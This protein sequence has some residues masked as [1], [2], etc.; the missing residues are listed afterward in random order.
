MAGKTNLSATL[1]SQKKLLGKSSTGTHRADSNEPIPSGLQVATSAVFAED[2]PSSPSRTLFTVQSAGTGKPNTVEYVEFK[3]QEVTG[4]AYDANDFDSEAGSQGS[5]IHAYRLVL[6]E[7]YQAN[8]NSSVKGTYPFVDNQILHWTLGGLQMVSPGFSNDLPNPYDLKLYESD[9]SE[10]PLLDE[11]DWQIDYFSGIL[12]VQDYD[13]SKIPENAKGFIYVGKMLSQSLGDISDL[14][15]GG[16]SP[17]TPNVGWHAPGAGSISTTGSLFIGTSANPEISLGSVG[18]AIFNE[19]GRNSDFRIE[20]VNKPSAFKVDADT[21]QVLILSGGAGSSVNE[22]AGSDVSFYVSGSVDSRGTVNRGTSVFGG[23]VAVSGTLSVNLSDA[24]VGS[25]FVVTTDGKVGI[26]T[27]NP[28][29]KLSVGGNMEVGEYIYHKNDDHTFIRFQEDQVHIKAGNK[30]MIKMKEDASDQVLIL[31]GGVKAS[32]DPAQ[33]EDTNFFV[34]G[35]IG[36]RGTLTAGTSVFGGDLVTSGSAE[37]FGDLF[38]NNSIAIGPTNPTHTLTVAGT[39]SST[40]GLSGSL[41]ALSDGSPY[42]LAGPNITLATGS[43]GAITISASGGGGG[44]GG[45]VSFSGGNGSDNQMITADGSGDIIAESNI[46]FNGSQLNVSGD[47]LPGADNSFDLGSPTA[48][49]ANIYTGDLHLRNERG[50]W[51]IVEEADALTVINRLTGKR[52]K[53]VLEPY[54]EDERE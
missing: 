36:S 29:Y 19:Q 39:I 25:Q 48:R 20:A 7:S 30:S 38:A 12:F 52:Y 13:A 23:D 45:S 47:I 11:I 15:G 42:L 3:L 51:Q 41:T 37:I 46:T 14:A 21:Q 2:V 32:P 8:S 6:S 54:E 50:H 4:S 17:H 5:G 24:A 16:G 10:I 43:T 18:G 44:G 27:S 22:A 31:S 35:S 34:S 9:G 28:A 53:M 26:G 49:F 1:F 40:E 33:F